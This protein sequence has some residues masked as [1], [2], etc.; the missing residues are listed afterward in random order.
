MSCTAAAAH[1]CAIYGQQALRLLLLLFCCL[2]QQLF[3]V[4]NGMEKNIMPRVYEIMV[5]LGRFVHGWHQDMYPLTWSMCAN[6]RILLGCLC[7]WYGQTLDHS[8]VNVGGSFRVPFQTYHIYKLILA[9]QRQS[10]LFF[11]CHMGGKAF[12][13]IVFM[14][15][16]LKTKICR[17]KMLWDPIFRFVLGPWEATLPS[18]PTNYYHYTIHMYTVQPAP[19]QT[20]SLGM[21]DL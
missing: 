8:F 5:F 19:L 18:W 15:M 10:P 16:R 11:P 17:R 1:C 6:V 9:Q 14:R 12:R 3:V 20:C 2:P 7:L 13:Q 21:L 4:Q